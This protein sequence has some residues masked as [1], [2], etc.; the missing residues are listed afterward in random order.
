MTI[1]LTLK[2]LRVESHVVMMITTIVTSCLLS[3]TIGGNEFHLLPCI[4]IL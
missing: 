3:D 2:E 1:Y 4:C